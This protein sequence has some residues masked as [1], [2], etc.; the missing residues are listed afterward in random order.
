ML[1]LNI[2]SLVDFTTFLNINDHFTYN[3]IQLK[4][5]VWWKFYSL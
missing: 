4:K 3:V 5:D 1:I 2:Y